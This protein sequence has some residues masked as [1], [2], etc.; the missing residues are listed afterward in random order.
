MAT[1]L[2]LVMAASACGDR[3][4]V[5]GGVDAVTY[6]ELRQTAQLVAAGRVLLRDALPA[7]ETPKALCRELRAAALNGSADS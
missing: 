5:G 7:T 2:L 6:T 3:L 4:A 1:P